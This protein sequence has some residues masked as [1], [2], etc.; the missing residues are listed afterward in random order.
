MS[1]SPLAIDC[2]PSIAAFRPEPQTLLMVIAGTMS[3]RPAQIAAWRAEWEKFIRPNF[4]IHATPIR[5]ERICAELSRHVPDDGIVVVD[6]GHAGMWMGG[7]F[8]LTSPRQSYMRSAGHLGWAFPAALG[9]K[10]ACPSRPVVCF[11]GDAGFWYHI[12]ELET[13]TTYDL[14]VKIVVLNNFGDGMVKQWQKLFFKGRLSASDRSLHKKDF[15]K[16]AHADGFRYAARLERK[17]DVPRVIGEFLAYPGP[18]FLE[19]MIDPDAGVYPMVGPG[20]AYD[21]MITG[22]YIVSRGKGPTTPPD[23][24]EMF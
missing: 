12:G 3:G 4:E 2:A 9:A 21:E 16:A 20:Q 13:V 22:D 7:M 15:V 10:A 11:T 17:A 23:A 5:P 8:D 6:T 1:A 19:V 18:A 24:S 14:P